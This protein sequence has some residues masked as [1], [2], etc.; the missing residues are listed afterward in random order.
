[1]VVISQC[2]ELPTYWHPID[3]CKGTI[4]MYDTLMIRRNIFR[5]ERKIRCLKVTLGDVFMGPVMITRPASMS[6]S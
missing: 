3:V 1:M 2:I 4:F 6:P 5:F